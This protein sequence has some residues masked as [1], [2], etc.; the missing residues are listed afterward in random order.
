M[1][2]CTAK[3]MKVPDYLNVPFAPPSI[4][5]YLY[6]AWLTE[7]LMDTSPIQTD[8]LGFCL[9][10]LLSLYDVYQATSSSGHRLFVVK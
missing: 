5:S 9:T 10:L 4:R 1:A 8:T 7:T 6:L 2:V 3:F